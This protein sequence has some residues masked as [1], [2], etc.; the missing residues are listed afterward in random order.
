MRSGGLR[1]PPLVTRSTSLSSLVESD[2]STPSRKRVR[3]DSALRPPPLLKMGSSRSEADSPLL[4]PASTSIG[5]T[6]RA[7]REM[8]EVLR[9]QGGTSKPA[10]QNARR[11]SP[12]SPPV[13]SQRASAWALPSRPTRGPSSLPTASR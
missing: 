12:V 7:A 9:K 8:S 6:M 2:N 10:P 1:P 13:T 3:L 5:R 11:S 4:L